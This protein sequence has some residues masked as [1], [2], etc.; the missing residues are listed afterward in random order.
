MER[1]LSKEFLSNFLF[2]KEEYK[3][4]N[5]QST[6]K[7][8]KK[9]EIIYDFSKDNESKSLGLQFEVIY[10]SEFD[11]NIA[12]YKTNLIGTNIKDTQ[13]YLIFKG[14]I[15]QNLS[16][17]LNLNSQDFDFEIPRPS[18]M[19]NHLEIYD[20]NGNEIENDDEEDWDIVYY[21]F[22][23]ENTEGK[24]VIS[25]MVLYAIESKNYPD[26]TLLGNFPGAYIKGTI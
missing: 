19:F 16:E 10:K 7:F 12:D 14:N 13:I 1:Q 21:K 9:C 17:K 20:E 25:T 8:L 18:P 26:Y 3:L 22:N 5:L 6:K 15:A 2:E 11:L 23:E 4:F 24:L